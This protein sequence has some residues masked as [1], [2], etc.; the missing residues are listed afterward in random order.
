MR[1]A[2]RESTGIIQRLSRGETS[3][4]PRSK[5]ARAMI[6]VPAKAII[7]IYPQMSQMFTDEEKYLCS[8]VASVDEISASEPR[9]KLAGAMTKTVARTANA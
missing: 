3:R 7:R 5:V 1:P 6:A 9:R 4:E 2:D 8:S